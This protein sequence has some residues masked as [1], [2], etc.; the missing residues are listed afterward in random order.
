MKSQRNYGIDLIRGISV[1]Y[2]VS[3]WH[4]FNYTQAFRGYYNPFTHNLTR[5]ILASFVFISGY[6]IASKNFKINWQNILTF[7]R[8]RLIRIYPLYALA[9]VLFYWQNIANSQTLI[10]AAFLLSMFFP[11]APYTLWFITMIMIF[12]LVAPFLLKY[13]NN[14]NIYLVLTGLL[15]LIFL[16][17]GTS[18]ISLYFPSFALAI[19]LRANPQWL[20]K[21]QQQQLILTI[22]FVILFVLKITGY[23]SMKWLGIEIFFINLGAILFYF[24]S[25]QIMNRV[26][27]TGLIEQ[28]SY[29]SFGMYLFHRPIFSFTK[30][31]FFPSGETAQVIYLLGVALPLTII[32]SW[33]IQKLYDRFVLS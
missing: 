3:Y 27:Y 18:E 17:K 22:T 21:L 25:Y 7:W 26:K 33:L 6:L 30:S 12:Y 14:L 28:M 15:W 19:W 8:K 10:K 32:I 2:I 13:A 29:V 4:L 23:L 1:F 9:L 20:D 24:Y 5:I 16:F 11:P 31:V